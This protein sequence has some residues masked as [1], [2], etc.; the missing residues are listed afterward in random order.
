MSSNDAAE[1]RLFLVLESIV[2]D[3]LSIVTTMTLIRL[4]QMP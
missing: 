2:T 4:I 3:S 1:C